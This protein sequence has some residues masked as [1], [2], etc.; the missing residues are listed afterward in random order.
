MYIPQI[1]G[2]LFSWTQSEEKP[3]HSSLSPE[4]K[5]LYDKIVK[6]ILQAYPGRFEHPDPSLS[7]AAPQEYVLIFRQSK[8]WRTVQTMFTEVQ[9]TD[10]KIQAWVT[11]WIAR[12]NDLRRS[13]GETHQYAEG[14]KTANQKR[15]CLPPGDKKISK[16]SKQIICIKKNLTDIRQTIIS[17]L[18][19]GKANLDSLDSEILKDINCQKVANYMR[20]YWLHLQVFSVWADV[21]LD[22]E[23]MAVKIRRPKTTDPIPYK[24]LVN[25]STKSIFII[26]EE[27]FDTNPVKPGN[28]KAGSIIRTKKV[29]LIE[30]HLAA[31]SPI[32]RKRSSSM[33][34]ISEVYIFNC[35]F[36][37]PEDMETEIKTTSATARQLER[38]VKLALRKVN[39]ELSQNK[40]DPLKLPDSE[41]SDIEVPDE[42]YS[43]VRNFLFSYSD[44]A[45]PGVQPSTSV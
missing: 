21:S 36:A 18:N 4:D 8:S 19:E 1:I 5:V 28:I 29:A 43:F 37:K 2:T 16:Y 25:T 42:P 23:K 11:S 24:D 33:K 40:S 15:G 6:D 14:L 7:S 35:D 3:S 22:E 34:V 9:S 31:E 20:D 26:K 27:A 41:S 44:P 30:K 32:A 13:Q 10:A 17:L 39:T 45:K 12:I 38:I